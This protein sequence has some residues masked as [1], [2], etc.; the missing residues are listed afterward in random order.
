MQRLIQPIL[1]F[2]AIVAIVPAPLAAQQASNGAGASADLSAY[3]GRPRVKALRLNPDETISIDGVLNEAVWQ[4]AIPA[5]DFI[6]QDPDLGQ[7]ATERT[8]VRFAFSRTA[9]YMGV[10][11]L[12]LGAGQTEGQQHAAR[13]FARRA[14][15]GS[16]GR[17]ILTWTAAPD[18][19]SK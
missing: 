1:L 16:C 11:C 13:R 19:S 12:R 6:Q 5:T 15:T 14:T 7:P 9:L 4:R 2:L 8:E 17:S 10:I 18:T 3:E